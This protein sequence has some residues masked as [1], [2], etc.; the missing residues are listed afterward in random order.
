MI[1][2]RTSGVRHRRQRQADVVDRDGDAHARHQLRVQR[3]GVERVVER[4]ADRRARVGQPLDGRLGVDDARA[5][6]QVFQQQIL[7]R[8][9][10]ARR[11]VVSM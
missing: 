7:A 8:E 6:R 1:V 5:D 11:R 2:C 4:V 9:Q 10:D 3:I